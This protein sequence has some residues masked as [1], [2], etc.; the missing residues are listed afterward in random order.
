M[1]TIAVYGSLKQGRYNH[2]MLYGSKYLGRTRL[3]GVMYL[4]STYPAF[5]PGE[6][7]S[8]ALHHSFEVYEVE[9]KVYED[10]SAMEKGAG[11]D[12]AEG[13]FMLS[14]N[15]VK[16]IY[17]PASKFLQEHCEKSRPVISSY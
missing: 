16:A 6:D 5:V 9:D 7:H 17:Y 12:V 13:T 8:N 3:P 11:Y 4:I 15:E 2:D 1:K 10:V 14:G